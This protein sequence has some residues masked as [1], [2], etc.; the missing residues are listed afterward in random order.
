MRVLSE[1]GQFRL[2]ICDS[3]CLPVCLLFQASDGSLKLQPNTGGDTD[4]ILEQCDSSRERARDNRSVIMIREGEQSYLDAFT[5]A[6][7][8]RN[9]S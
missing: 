7:L 1:S 6:C 2:Q 3:S 5:Q 8:S 9:Q 4:K